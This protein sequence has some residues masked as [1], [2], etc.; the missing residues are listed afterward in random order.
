M[1]GS[2]SAIC[3]YPVKGPSPE[4]WDK[5]KLTAGRNRRRLD[6]IENGRTGFDPA[7]AGLSSEVALFDAV[8]F[9]P[10]S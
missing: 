7:R 1:N 10:R 9:T 3:P 6:A 2:I 5:G 4:L 8:Q